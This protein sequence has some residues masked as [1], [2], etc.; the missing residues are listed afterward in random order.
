MLLVV[1]LRAMSTASGTPAEMHRSI[2]LIAS[3]WST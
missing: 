2:A 1:W 3:G